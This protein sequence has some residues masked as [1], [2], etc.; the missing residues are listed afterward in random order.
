LFLRFA[1]ETTTF[2]FDGVNPEYETQQ[3][4]II[5]GISYATLPSYVVGGKLRPYYVYAE[6]RGSPSTLGSEA[7]FLQVR[8]QGERIF[9]LTPKWHLRLRAEIGASWVPDF[10][11]LPASQRF[12]AGGDRSVRGFDL[13]ELSPPPDPLPDQPTRTLETSVGGKHLLTGTVEFERDLPKN[14]VLASF[15]DAGNAF[16][17]F[18]DPLEYSV[19]LGVRYRVSVASLGIDLAQPL[20]EAGRGPKLHL[21]I[22]TLF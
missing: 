5:P 10:S 13:N 20:S 2:P 4:L 1:D 19:G 6:L 3:F 9:P 14:F 21:Y 18:G 7:S 22:S 17:E 12:F 8:L 16:N 15:F 11:D